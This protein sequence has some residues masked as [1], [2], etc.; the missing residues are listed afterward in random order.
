MMMIIIMEEEELIIMI[1]LIKNLSISS[2]R[3]HLIN[4]FLQNNE[5]G[6]I[7]YEWT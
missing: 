3:I 7:Q 6:I 5:S 1:L 4:N 2:N